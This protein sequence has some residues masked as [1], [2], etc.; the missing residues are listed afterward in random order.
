MVLAVT[1]LSVATAQNNNSVAVSI[2]EMLNTLTFS[3]G[4]DISYSKNFISLWIELN[5]V[6]IL[7]NLL[8]SRKQ[9]QKHRKN[10]IDITLICRCL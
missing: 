5:I 9:K 4:R 10:A 3:S 1:L 7:F 8:I 2:M 6:P